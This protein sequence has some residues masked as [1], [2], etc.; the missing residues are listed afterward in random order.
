MSWNCRAS[1]L[2]NIDPPRMTGA[3][4]QQLAAMVAKMFDQVAELHPLCS[5]KSFF[6]ADASH[7]TSIFTIEFKCFGEGDA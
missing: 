6:E 7:S 2:L 1:I 4:T 3:F 5:D